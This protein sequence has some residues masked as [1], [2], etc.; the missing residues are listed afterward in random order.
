M[1]YRILRRTRHVRTAG[2]LIT[3]SWWMVITESGSAHRNFLPLI[4]PPASLNVFRGRIEAKS[5]TDSE[6]NK[7]LGLSQI[8]TRARL[9]K[10]RTA[11]ESEADVGADH[12][13]SL[14]F[15]AA[16]FLGCCAGEPPSFD[17]Y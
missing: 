9:A 10:R 16:D 6:R 2:V 15:A 13:S 5:H 4:L 14:R 8:L 3:C 11:H 7:E 1:H 17:H 12:C